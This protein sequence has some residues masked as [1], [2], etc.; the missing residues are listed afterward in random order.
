MEFQA[1]PKLHR[2]SK[3]IIITEK[4]DGTNACVAIEEVVDPLLLSNPH[5]L[6]TCI[7]MVPLRD[8]V[9]ALHAQSRNRFVLPDDDNYGFAAW[10]KENASELV[11]LGPGRHFGEWWGKGI[12]R[13]YGLETK[14]FS[15]FNT[16]RRTNNPP[17]ACC[18]L[19]PVL[20][21]GPFYAEIVEGRLGMLRDDGSVAAPGFM[22]PEGVV[23]FH[24]AARVGFK[25]TLEH[26]DIP[27]SLLRKTSVETDI[28]F[29]QRDY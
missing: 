28:T 18:S 29:E 7:D 19:V 9:Y 20:Y 4:I 16:G 3:D 5:F 21:T 12:Q 10:V 23:V 17:P 8:R 11:K 13:T 14:K 24:T 22:Q 15:L 25:K 27:K 1:F 6:A 2:L 26:D